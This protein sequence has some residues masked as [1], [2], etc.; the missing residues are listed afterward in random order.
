MRIYYA[1]FTAIAVTVQ[2]DFFE[3]AT[4]AATGAELVALS[5]TQE[6]STTSEMLTVLVKR[7]Q[8]T[9]GSGGAT[10]T[11]ARRRLN[12]SVALSTVKRNN[13][14]KASAGTIVTLRAET[15]NV[16]S[17]LSVIWLPEDR[18]RVE[19]SSRCTVELSKTPAASLTM[20]GT[21]TFAELN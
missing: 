10:I 7:G 3:I 1:T 13:T 19:P 4:P 16:L 2:Q 14:T 21:L 20:S 5:L 8:T 17:G 12:D 15:F 9:T 11:P 6:N 18:P